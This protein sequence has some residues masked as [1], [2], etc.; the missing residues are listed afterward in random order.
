MNSLDARLAALTLRDERTLR[1]RLE[2]GATAAELEGALRAAEARV[3]RRR[4]TVP[5]PRYPEELPIAERRAD[6]LEALAAHQV[7]V[8]AGE[9]GSGKSTQLPKICLEA[10]RGVRGLIGHTQPRRIAARTL[11]ERVADELG[12]DV[13]D[14]VG[15]TVRFTDRVGE[16]TLVKL[17]TDGILL[18]ELQRDRLLTRYDTLIIDEAHERSLNIDF[19]LGYLK[20]LLPQRPDLKVV[21]TSATIDTERFSRHFDDAPVVEVSGRTYPVEIRYQPYGEEDDDDR[22]QVQAIVDAVEEVLDAGPG[23]VLVFLSG[24]REIR[25]TA[26]AL[27]RLDRRDLD[28]LPLYARLSIAEQHRVF[29]PHTGRR[30]VLATN[31]AET[32]LT[33]PGIRAVVDPGTARVSRYSRRTKVQ[34]LPIEPVSQASANQRAGRCGRIGPGLCIRLY[35]EDD[36][37]SREAYTEPEILRTNLASVILQMTAIGLGDVAAFPF[38]DPPDARNIRDGVALLEELGALDGQ[39]LTKIGRRLAQLPI[40]PRLG[41]MV[42]EADGNGCLREVMVIAAAL[43]IQDPRERPADKREAADELHGRFADPESD[44]LTLVNLWTYLREK[45]KEL[46]SSQFRKLCRNELLNYVRV[47]EWQDI[48]SQLR[49]V[50]RQLGMHLNDGDGDGRKDSIHISVLAGLLSHI[51]MRDADKPEYRGARDARFAIAPGSVL[52]KKSPKWVMAAELVETNRM[53]GRMAARIQP[54]WAERLGAHLVKRSYSDP[55]WDPNRASAFTTE[56]VGLYGLPVVAGRRVPYARIDR[57]GGR[58]MFIWNALVLNDWEPHHTFVADNRKL[59]DEVRALE[60]RARRRD[61]LVD[62]DDLYDFFDERVPDTV[63]SGKQFDSWWRRERQARPDLLSF[64]LELLLS[65]TARHVSHDSYPDVWHQG[66]LSLRLSYELDPASEADGVT[67]HVPLPLLN[68]VREEGFDW[69]VPGLRDEL[70]VALIRSLPKQLRRSF[71]PVPDYART[72]LSRTDPT[73][74]PLVPALARELTT[75][76]GE[77]VRAN[78]FDLGA[79]PDHLRISFRVEDEDGATVALGK[80]LEAIRRRL[81]GHMQAALVEAVQS[82]DIT[83]QRSWTFGTIDPVVERPWAGTTVQAYPALVDEGDTVGL[84]VL[85]GPGEQERAMWAG[86]RRLLLLTI[87]SPKKTLDRILPMRTKL[88]LGRAPHGSMAAV[89]DDCIAA[90][91]DALLRRN[92]G[93]VWDEPAFEALREA[94]RGDVVDVAMRIAGLVGDVLT[95]TAAVEERLGQLTAP[96]VEAAVSDVWAQVFRLIRPGFVTTTGAERLPW[97]LRYL[98]AIERRLERVAADPR[99]DAALMARVQRLERIHEELLLDP[100]RGRTVEEVEEVGW[101]IEELRV[102]LWAQ[103]LGTAFPVSEKRIEKALDAL[104]VAAA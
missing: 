62:D 9:T 63:T 66:D 96:A 13:G 51:G 21:I 59:V 90:A 35:S 17:M 42:L 43:S 80:D 41:R 64:T 46:S 61:L 49:Q 40:D 75:M 29:Q 33:V 16:N 50:T 86:T 24:E 70:V 60:A 52:F 57:A 103:T 87:P 7:V 30:V 48:Y 93:P 54:E 100:P 15:Y 14:V 88:V 19:I 73:A 72:F 53:W 18:A 23:D 97:V 39:R 8:V 101:M 3:E 77:L 28:V 32:S 38:V 102:S 4:A 58:E 11:A 79:V 27:T 25:D 83:G 71:V 26:E 22:D 68:K 95:A 81:R 91:V 98:E 67:V 34:R 45:Q 36:F 89:L 5:A 6:I 44:L 82:N 56:R 65:P 74:G 37:E 85:A 104:R 78:S 99:R 84:R 47:R 10:G 76:S 69:Q 94:V 2:G 12:T 55:V 92:G 20:Q 31:V 1:R